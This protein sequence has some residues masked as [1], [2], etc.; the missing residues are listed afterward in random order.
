MSRARSSDCE[1]TRS[2]TCGHCL[3]NMKPW[4]WSRSTP[5]EDAKYKETLQRREELKAIHCK[6]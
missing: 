4:V 3:S 2:F 5:E 6:G 1:C